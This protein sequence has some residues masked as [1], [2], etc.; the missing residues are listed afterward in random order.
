MT[1]Q[2]FDFQTATALSAAAN[3]AFDLINTLDD[4]RDELAFYALRDLLI[5]R[6]A[7]PTDPSDAPLPTYDYLRSLLRDIDARIAYPH[8]ETSRQRLSMM[9]LDFSLCPLHAI[10]YAICFDDDNPEC[11]TIRALFPSHDT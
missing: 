6:D 2:T 10:D 7:M 4:H 1:N 8:D 3:R 5:D 11:A 9:L